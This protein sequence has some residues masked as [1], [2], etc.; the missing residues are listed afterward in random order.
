MATRVRIPLG[1]AS[2]ETLRLKGPRIGSGL[3]STPHPSLPVRRPA[4]ARSLQPINT[5]RS[6]RLRSES[7][8]STVRR[9]L[10]G[11]AEG[12]F[13]VG[14]LPP[15]PPVRSRGGFRVVGL[16]EP[17]FKP[18]DCL[19]I[20]G[21][22][23]P[24]VGERVDQVQSPASGN[25]VLGSGFRITGVLWP[26][27]A[28][29]TCRR[30][31]DALRVTPIRPRPWVAALVINS[32]TARRVRSLSPARPRALR[33]LPDEAPRLGRGTGGALEGPTCLPQHG[34]TSLLVR[35]LALIYASPSA[36][37]WSNL[38]GPPYRSRRRKV[39][40]SG[41]S[42]C[43]WGAGRPSQPPAGC[44]SPPGMAPAAPVP[45]PRPAG[46]ARRP[47]APSTRWS[48]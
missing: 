41:G 8:P 34:T 48:Q 19:M 13:G 14:Q 18:D 36:P 10:V 29:A 31:P 47:P 21:V 23:A 39:R 42:W 33:H 2:H 43:R 24:V 3:C 16:G 45:G 9:S 11:S 27:S 37:R 35:V 4:H 17:V 26:S 6:L 25:L 5:A 7:S 20:L 12:Y 28:T 46:G 44:A 32:L 30:S 15:N 38:F 1:G 40:E 22:D